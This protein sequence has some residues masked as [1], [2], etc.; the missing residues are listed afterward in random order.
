MKLSISAP[1]SVYSD[2]SQLQPG[3]STMTTPKRESSSTIILYASWTAEVSSR[4]SLRESKSI[5]RTPTRFII[6]RL[7]AG[8]RVIQERHAG[9]AP[10]L[11]QRAVYDDAR[12]PGPEILRI[13]ERSQVQQRLVGGVPDYIERILLV[14]DVGVSYAVVPCLI[15]L[16]SLGKLEFVHAMNLPFHNCDEPSLC[17]IRQT[18]AENSCAE[19]KKFFGAPRVRTKWQK[20]LQKTANRPN[21]LN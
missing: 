8:Q 4:L 11:I 10:E 6:R 3:F 15:R 7:G 9:T 13:L 21:S 12:H 20:S 5:S 1:G 19:N 18:G 14:F 2:T 16:Q 17:N